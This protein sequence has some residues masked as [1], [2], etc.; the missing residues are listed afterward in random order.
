[1]KNSNALQGIDIE[2]MKSQVKELTAPLINLVVTDVSVSKKELSGLRKES[3]AIDL[4]LKTRKD[5]LM[6][7]IKKI[8]SVRKE[9]KTLFS[10]A[11]TNLKTQLDNIEIERK[12]NLKVEI[13]ERI[14]ALLEEK[15]INIK[16]CEINIPE[17]LL[18]A[19]TTKKAIDNHINVTVLNASNAQDK[20]Y[21][22][23]ESIEN[24]V[25]LM[26]EAFNLEVPVIPD[27]Y[28][29]KLENNE[30]SE[31]IAMITSDTKKQSEIE[32]QA[33]ERAEK[34]RLQ[35]IE[36][37]RIAKERAEKIRLEAIEREKEKAEFIEEI[38]DDP[39]LDLEESVVE[40]IKPEPI[41]EEIPVVEEKIAVPGPSMK[42]KLITVTVNKEKWINLV[43]FLKN[44]NIKFK[45]EEK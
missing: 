36:D 6:P 25:Q 9:F 13:R 4:V 27:E 28:I 41:K 14:L 30:V 15:V 23:V 2:V 43:K 7:V 29:N 38:M 33:I 8:D 18:N 10:E 3:K 17:A 19:S 26:N 31:I 39:I 45:Q 34:K 11:E 20:Y 37:E 16:F 12:D 21:K 40:D 35:K 32:K 44:E 42:D 5:E 1:M 22:D 24:N